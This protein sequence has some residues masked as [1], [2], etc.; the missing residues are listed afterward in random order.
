MVDNG[1]G[2]TGLGCKPRVQGASRA[3]SRG[4]FSSRES[5]NTE[6]DIRSPAAPEI[7]ADS[8]S[9]SGW[10]N[11]VARDQARPAG[12][13]ARRPLGGGFSGLGRLID[14]HEAAVLHIV[15]VA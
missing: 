2:T 11:L 10:E 9:S 13:P 14:L 1:L 6:T 15:N 7:G 8:N 12:T 5:R 3:R 4:R